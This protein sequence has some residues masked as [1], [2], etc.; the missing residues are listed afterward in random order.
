MNYGIYCVRDKRK[1]PPMSQ[2]QKEPPQ[3]GMAAR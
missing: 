3:P 1:T 2:G